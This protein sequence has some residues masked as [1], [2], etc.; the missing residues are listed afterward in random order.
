M[1]WQP[2]KGLNA[3]LPGGVRV[4]EGHNPQLPL[5]AWYIRVREKD[6]RIT[7][8][9]VV[10]M[11][12]D[13]RETATEFAQRLGA[14]VVVNGGY[15][16]MDLLP[17]EHVG[18]LKVDGVLLEPPTPCVQRDGLRFRLARAA[19]GFT[20]D[21]HIDVAWVM[22]Y[23]DTLMEVIQPLRNRPGLPDTLF[24]VASA[25][26]WHMHDALA[27]GPCLISGGEIRITSDEEVFFGTSVPNV[28]PRTA[29]GY[30]Q[31][32]ELILLVV[33]GRQDRS[34]GV[35]LNE[36]AIIMKDLGCLEAL[37]LDGGGSS[38]LV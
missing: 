33:D 3:S 27:A 24:E 10:S 22:S 15:F 37:N 1:N 9:V 34:R 7:T 36:L 38:T 17:A 12:K 18:L 14:C 11:D 25:R 16:R 23:S 5:R 20:K 4:Y 28:H 6:T 13:R 2:M 26:P 8:H 30:T 32:G 35:D 31:N 21:D 19:L 29:A